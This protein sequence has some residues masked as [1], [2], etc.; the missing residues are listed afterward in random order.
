VACVKRALFRTF[1]NPGWSRNNGL[2]SLL[3]WYMASGLR[4]NTRNAALGFALL[5]AGALIWVLAPAI[6]LS[7]VPEPVNFEQP[8]PRVERLG[9][10]SVR[11]AADGD[12]GSVRF[13]SE[14]IAA[15]KR[16]DLVGLVDQKTPVEVRA[17][18]AGGE[19]SPWVETSGGEP[20]WTGGSDELQLR[21]HHDRPEGEI[22]Y[23]NVSGDATRADWALNAARGA[24][25]SAFVTVASAFDADLAS[26]DAP[27]EVVNRSEW[28]P[29]HDCVP[30]SSPTGVVK[31]GVVHHTVNP[32]N[33]S[34]AAAPSIVL[35]ICRYH[36]YTQGWNDIG[37]NALVDRFGNIYAGRS[38]GLTNAV[39]GAH[40]AGFNSQTFGVASIGDYRG[41]GLSPAAIDAITD[42][43]AW[44]LSLHGVDGV[45]KTRV[46]S[47]GGATSKYPPG[48]K[49]KTKE[50]TR[51]RRFGQTEC[52]G[53]AQINKIL[54]KTRKKIASGQFG[55]E[56]AEPPPP[57]GGVVLP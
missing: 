41:V 43:L 32:N 20:V 48:K 25:N 10:P 39:I 14:P 30:K 4:R 56:P 11:G 26:G 51:H 49:V 21:S 55:G 31:A 50:V 45:G 38:G 54:K 22:G 28:D 37:Y 29:G 2:G 52:P 13:L 15:P 23:V 16:F 17:R 18:E 44:K 9:G 12:H 47:A 3:H 1:C 8:V 7:Y 6:S 40:T 33:Y 35:G 19:W 53:D 24:A 27:F 46:E 42:V 5:A 34:E 57:D 36:R